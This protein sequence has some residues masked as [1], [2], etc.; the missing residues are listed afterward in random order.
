MRPENL[1]NMGV[2]YGLKRISLVNETRMR[3]KET[4]QCCAP[5]KS[6]EIIT[7]VICGGNRSVFL[8]MGDLQC[9]YTL[10]EMI[11][12]ERKSADATDKES[13]CWSVSSGRWEKMGSSVQGKEF[14][15]EWRTSE[16]G[17]HK[18]RQNERDRCRTLPQLSDIGM[19]TFSYHSSFSM[20][21]IW[22]LADSEKEKR[23][24]D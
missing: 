7:R 11:K 2:T 14:T 21:S 15:L 23:Y 4:I 1:T 12:L 16:A 24:G 10:M 13:N 22:L 9:V 5:R 19:W 8:K 3:E 6:R 18:R 17:W 20:K